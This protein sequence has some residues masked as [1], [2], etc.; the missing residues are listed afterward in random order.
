MTHSNETW[1]NAP[2]SNM[3]HHNPNVITEKIV[4]LLRQNGTMSEDQIGI[5]LNLSP[6][7]VVSQVAND[8][9]LVHK[10][11]ARQQYD[12]ELTRYG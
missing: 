11:T 2:Q 10:F 8:K 3:D 1:P 12:I 6:Q 4:E 5:E 9:R 7:E